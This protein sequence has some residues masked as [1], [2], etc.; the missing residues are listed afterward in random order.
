MPFC[1]K[2][3]TYCQKLVARNWHRVGGLIDFL[4][5]E[6]VKRPGGVENL[7]GGLTPRTPRQLADY[8]G[9]F[10]ER[11]KNDCIEVS[12]RRDVMQQYVINHHSSEHLDTFSF[13]A[14]QCQMTVLHTC[15]IARTERTWFYLSPRATFNQAINQ[16]I[17]QSKQIY[18]APLCRRQIKAAWWPEC[19]RSAR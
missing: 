4:G 18:I 17:S 14:E 2:N 9:K 16:S 19:S 12:K 15:T 13:A 6:G 7:A 8:T 1:E 10:S 5:T 11:Y 3:Y